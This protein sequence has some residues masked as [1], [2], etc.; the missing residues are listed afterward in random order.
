L[1]RGYLQCNALPAEFPENLSL[2]LK[3][4]SMKEIDRQAAL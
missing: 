1:C 4:I 2:D 3:V